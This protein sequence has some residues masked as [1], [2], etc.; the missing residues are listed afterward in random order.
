M[1]Q[2]IALVT[3]ASRGIGQDIAKR[4]VESGYYVIGT[5]TSGKLNKSIGIHESLRVDFNDR[6]STQ[7]FLRKLID[8]K[9]IEILVNN[10]GINIIKQQSLITYE[11]FDLIEDIN[12]RAPFFISSIVAKSM[13]E[14]GGGKIVNIASIWSVISKENRTLYSTMKSGL[15]GLT[16]SM[17]V[18]WAK[19]NVLINSVSPG[20]VNT[21]LTNRSLTN[22]EIDQITKQ[23]PLNRMA[24]PNEISELV[25]FLTS[26]QNTYV[27]GQNIIIDGGFTI[28]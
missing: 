3:G 6:V 23:I 7:I 25:F 4:F 1:T 5:S 2:K 24:E 16:R 9:K 26:K 15:H 11:D 10:A 12:L 27:T 19:N 18:E 13:A 22:T 21:E 8:Y 28:I 14:A 20:F 17:A